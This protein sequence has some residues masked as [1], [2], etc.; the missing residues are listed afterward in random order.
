MQD[1]RDHALFEVDVVAAEDMAA[2]Q[3]LQNANGRSNGLDP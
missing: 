1:V 3:S 2:N